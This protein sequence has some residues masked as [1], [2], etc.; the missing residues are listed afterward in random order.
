MTTP[1]PNPAPAMSGEDSTMKR[2]K[3]SRHGA[4]LGDTLSLIEMAGRKDALMELPPMCATC[5]FRRDCMTN[6]MAATGIVAL[7]CVLGIDKDRFACHH[8][9]KDG[10]PS[11]LCVGYVA[12]RLAPFSFTKEVL[13]TMYKQLGEQPESPDK[14]RA[15]FDAWLAEIDPEG[16]LNDYELARAYAARKPLR[17]ATQDHQR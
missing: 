15:A 11:K 17:P 5:A 14:V 12:A 7:N 10:Q 13:V 4:I 6:Q 2:E 16:K 1:T 8:G 3:P 9:M